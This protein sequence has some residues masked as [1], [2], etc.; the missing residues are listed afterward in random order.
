MAVEV[1]AASRNEE[2]ARWFRFSDA[3][4][5]AKRDGFGMAQTGRGPLPRWFAETF[6]L[7]RASAASPRGAFAK[8]AVDATRT[9]AA[10]AAA[11]GLLSTPANT[12]RAQVVAGR[13]YARIALTATSLG[14][15][16]QPMS[17]ALEEYAEMASTKARV[18]RE[19][20]L[21]RGWTAQMLFRLGHATPTPHTARR[22]VREMMRGG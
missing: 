1:S 2:T 18:E 14:L 6:V 15:A 21:E 13:A 17:Q 11:F 22:D 7:D 5:E 20:G 19:S 10:S 12:R 3:E 4:V 8:G 9:Q 16:M